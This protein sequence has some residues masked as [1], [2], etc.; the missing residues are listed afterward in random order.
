ML[1]WCSNKS[2]TWLFNRW[3]ENGTRKMIETW[4]CTLILLLQKYTNI[5]FL[6]LLVWTKML[7]YFSVVLWI[8]FSYALSKTLSSFWVFKLH[9]SFEWQK[10]PDFGVVL[11]HYSE[12]DI[13]VLVFRC[14]V[15]KS[16][17]ITW[18]SFDNTCPLN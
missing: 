18:S 16:S 1:F 12:W 7:L 2:H 6:T 17:V 4:L 8:R 3:R 13:D 10:R 15:W 14:P 11:D 5:Y 9:F